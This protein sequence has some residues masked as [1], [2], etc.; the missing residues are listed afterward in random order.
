MISEGD[1]IG[2]VCE[3]RR[4]VDSVPNESRSRPTASR[5][6]ESPPFF[7]FADIFYPFYEIKHSV[8]LEPF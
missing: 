6:S 1:V 8:C 7:Y 5:K 4:L 3:E 2:G